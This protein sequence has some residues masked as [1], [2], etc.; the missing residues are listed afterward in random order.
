[1]QSFTEAV[2]HYPTLKGDPCQ[3]AAAD[4]IR[5]C[6]TCF[7]AVSGMSRPSCVEVR[8][9]YLSCGVGCRASRLVGYPSIVA[10]NLARPRG[11]ENTERRKDNWRRFPSSSHSVSIRSYASVK[12]CAINDRS[13]W[14]QVWRHRPSCNP[15]WM[16]A[17]LRTRQTRQVH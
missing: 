14:S 6:V 16:P 3:L 9:C 17:T 2:L 1:M 4:N 11:I 7:T 13:F 8:H 12:G 10:A 5:I 15:A